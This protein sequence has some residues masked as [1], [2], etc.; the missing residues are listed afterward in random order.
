MGFYWI[1]LGVAAIFAIIE[2]CTV[3]FFGLWMA[4]AALVPAIVSYLCPH[5]SVVMQLLIWALSSL[6]CAFIWVKWIR[7][8]PIVHIESA[9]V[10]SEGILAEALEPGKFG[11]LLLSRPIQ[12]KQEW[13]CCS[14]HSLARQTRVTAI[15]IN[16]NDIVKVQASSSLKEGIK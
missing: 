12:G 1:W 10:G 13:M 7:S 15:A 11:T 3:T 16:E 6:V 4:I 2:F 9:I 8:K 14:D 5:L